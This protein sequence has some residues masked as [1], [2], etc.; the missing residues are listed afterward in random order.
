MRGALADSASPADFMVR[1]VRCKTMTRKRCRAA[2]DAATHAR[3]T[4]VR[5]A[6]RARDRHGG[7]RGW[8]RLRR[9]RWLPVCV[10]APK[11]AAVRYF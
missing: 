2:N 4:G 1:A 6:C 11:Q 8:I 3:R 5:T 7:G 9:K 10:S